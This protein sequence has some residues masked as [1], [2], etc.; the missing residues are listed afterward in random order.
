MQRI[1]CAADYYDCDTIIE[2]LG[3]N[4]LV[5]SKLIDDVIQYYL[6]GKY[7]YC[8]TITSETY[9]KHQSSQ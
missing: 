7:D 8:A 6:K 2:I 3:D 5:H 1:S 9:F 4:P